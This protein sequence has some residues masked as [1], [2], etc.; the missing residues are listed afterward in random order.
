[1]FIGDAGAPII[2][3]QGA[4][5]VGGMPLNSGKWVWVIGTVWTMD[6]YTQRIIDAIH[7]LAETHP[8]AKAGI[9]TGE[10][11][12]VPHLLDLASLR[13]PDKTTYDDTD[14]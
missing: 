12:G 11:D 3:V 9:A 1:V 4:F 5:G 13:R 14:G 6:E 10:A 7:K 2:N 8:D